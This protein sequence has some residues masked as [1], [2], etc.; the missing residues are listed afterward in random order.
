MSHNK[1]YVYIL[2][3]PRNN[4]PFYIGKGIRHRAY[5][6]LKLYKS[7]TT[8][9]LKINKVKK[10]LKMNLLPIV[11]IYKENL[12]EQEALNIET[13][14][15]KKY[16]RIC[17]NSGILTNFL[18]DSRCLSGENNPNF[19]NKWST[20]QKK[21]LSD[22]KVGKT[23]HK[24]TE[25]HKMY[26]S[27]IQP[28]HSFYSIDI[29]TYNVIKWDSIMEFKKFLNLKQH[30]NIIQSLHNYACKIK[31]YYLREL[32]YKNI[33]NNKIK[34]INSFKDECNRHKCFYK[35]TIQKD[36]MGNII[37]IWNSRKEAIDFYDMKAS[38]LTQA[39]KFKRTYKNFIWE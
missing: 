17:D 23:G 27:S 34:D 38:S 4:L 2:I 11:Q 32:D 26:M 12:E 20:E 29:N 36:L 21:N 19:G 15:I 22:K 24:H 5:M 13:D 37:K 31:N 28:K 14:L 35:K 39:I 6:H 7:D 10:L 16:G 18:V 25:E 1:F 3:D 30:C 8:N 9:K 33:E